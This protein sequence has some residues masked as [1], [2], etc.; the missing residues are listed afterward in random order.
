MIVTNPPDETNKQIIRLNTEE[1]EQEERTSLRPPE[2]NDAHRGFDSDGHV[3]R[4]CAQIVAMKAKLSND[5]S[6]I[7]TQMLTVW[8]IQVTLLTYIMQDTYLQV[9]LE[10]PQAIPTF[11]ITLTR[12]LSGLVLHLALAP[13]LSQGMDKMKFA[14]NHAWRFDSA[15]LA[16]IAGLCQIIV[17]VFV[18]TLM[19]LLAVLSH[20]I[21][22]V[23][24]SFIALYVICKFDEV[25]YL[26][27]A[28]GEVILRLL[29]DAKFA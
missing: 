26:G 5:R 2:R 14:L 22:E 13:K 23:I 9:D 18:E 7:L 12:F 1:E 20:D 6:H 24:M 29:K 17:V 28:G 16:A 8:L 25:F 4:E 27:L 15:W 19:Y 10:F 21:V 3:A 11:R